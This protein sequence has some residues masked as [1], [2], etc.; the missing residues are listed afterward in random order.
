MYFKFSG[1]TNIVFTYTI[2]CLS[3]ISRAA[4]QSPWFLVMTMKKIK[5][6]TKISNNAVI[7]KLTYYNEK[8][9]LITESYS[10]TDLNYSK[11]SKN[12]AIIS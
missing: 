3:D 2:Q 9:I 7:F 10:K 4:N 1:P 12:D 11:T 8:N 5:F 6:P